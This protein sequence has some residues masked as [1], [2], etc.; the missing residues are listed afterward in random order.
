MGPYSKVLDHNQVW[1]VVYYVKSLQH[2]Y[3]DSV[4]N[5]ASKVTATVKADTTKKK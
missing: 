2:H 5:A 4:A 1:K 3:Q